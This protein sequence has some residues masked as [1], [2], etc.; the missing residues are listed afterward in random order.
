MCVPYISG[1]LSTSHL[2]LQENGLS[3]RREHRFLSQ[4]QARSCPFNRTLG[5][6]SHPLSTP[7]LSGTTT[8]GGFVGAPLTPSSTSGHACAPLCFSDQRILSIALKFWGSEAALGRW[9][10][11]VSVSN[12]G[13]PWLCRVNPGCPLNT[14][15]DPGAMANLH[16]L[17]STSNNLPFI[18][19]SFLSLSPLPPSCLSDV[20]QSPTCMEIPAAPEA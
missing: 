4:S 17:F 2:C 11:E 18:G 7:L 3:Q 6:L 10:R 15:W 19:F 16:W 13:L 9:V 14:S 20:S 5:L 8:E 1:S 12:P